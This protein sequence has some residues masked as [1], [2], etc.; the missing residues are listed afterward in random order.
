[1]NSK[2]IQGIE[3]PEIG[4]GTF[5]LIGASGEQVLKSALS[6]GYRHIDTAQ[7]YQNEKMVGQA[8]KH[9]HIDREDLFLTTK[10]DRFN[11]EPA[12]LLASMEESLLSLQVEYVDLLLIHW[13][14]NDIQIKKTLEAMFTLKEQGRTLNIGVSNFPLAL[15]KE[16]VQDLGAQIF[17][18]QVEYHAMLGQFDLLDFAVE[19]DLLITAY[20]PLAQGHILKNPLLVEIGEK[21]GKTS[22]QIAL[23]WLVEQEQVVAI[24]KSTSVSH[25]QENINIYDFELQDDDFYAIDELEKSLRIVNPPFAP[26]WD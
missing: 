21:Y 11:L 16:V 25:L 8:L 5:K 13:P 24:P 1:M 10:I 4:L 6:M 14:R 17:C 12:R 9:A 22:A 23:R 3:V 15:V 7:D 18:N 20:S 19:N 26:K 2:N